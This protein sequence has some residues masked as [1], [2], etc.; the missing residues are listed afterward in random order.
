[1]NTEK[2]N[3][4]ALNPHELTV[5]CSQLSMLIKSGSSPYESIGIMLADTKDPGGRAILTE[6]NTHLEQGEKLHTALSATGT[7]PEYASHMITIGEEAGELDTVLDALSAFYEREDNLNESIRAALSYPLIMIG[8]MFVVILVLITQVLPIFSQVFAQL[9]TGMNA[10]SESLLRLGVT[11]NRYS[12]VLV[13]VLVLLALFFR[14]LFHARGGRKLLRRI[15]SLFPASRKL[16]LEIAAGRFASGMAL[17]LSSG[18]DTYQSLEMVRPVVE[19]ADVEAKI[20]ETARLIS[21]E[22]CTFPEALE[23]TSIFTQ[24]YTRMVKT[25]FKS[26]SL[27]TT[28]RQI[29]DHYERATSRKISALISVVEPTLI[30]VLSVIVGLILLSVIMPLMGIMGSIG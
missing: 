3:A 17:M 12:L 4:R 27:D 15:G 19:N 7:F 1:M 18:M 16:S 9:G 26:G 29:A 21:E 20:T 24:L 5:F 23:K 14:Y 11:L 13:A 2:K 22:G 10:F 30:I 6:M 8:I 25:G 28:L